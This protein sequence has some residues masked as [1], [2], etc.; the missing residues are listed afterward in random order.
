MEKNALKVATDIGKLTQAFENSQASDKVLFDKHDKMQ[1]KLDE[2][3]KAIQESLENMQA[4]M[5]A[6]I[7]GINKDVGILKVDVS[8][9]KIQWGF[10]SVIGGGVVSVGMIWLKKWIGK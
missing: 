7:S 8:K 9:M 10:L 1:T 2:M 5:I 4:T 6:N 3:Q